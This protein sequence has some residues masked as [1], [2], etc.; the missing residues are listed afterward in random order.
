LTLTIRTRTTWYCWLLTGLYVF[1]VN[2]QGNVVP[3]LQEAFAMSYRAVSLHSSAAAAGIMLVGLFGERVARRLGRQRSLWLAAGGFS[4]GG[5]LLCLAPAPWASITACFVTGL[6]G[7]LAPAVTPVVLADLHGPRRAAAYAGQGIVAYCYGLAAPLLSGL[8]IWAGFG[9]RPAVLA[10]AIVGIAVAFYFR[11]L[12]SAELG[13]TPQSASAAHSSARR[14]SLPAKLPGAY[15]AFWAMVV[16]TVSLEVGIVFWA[17]A[18]LE[19]VVGFTA[20]GAAAAA[21]GFPLG[22]LIGRIL[23]RTLVARVALR[24]LMVTSLALVALG[25]VLYWGIATPVAAIAGVF[26]LGLGIGPT[27]PLGTEFC[28]GAAPAAVPGAQD[29]ASTRLAIAFGLALL[30]APIALGAL[31][32]VLALGPAHLALPVLVL[33]SF[34]TFFAGEALQARDQ[35]S[36]IRDQRAA[37]QAVPSDT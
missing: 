36:G 33:A 32:D 14:A 9:W 1:S 26:I 15:W 11:R 30:A 16:A 19:R 20:A 35:V 28:V 24:R 2:I 5:I 31:A 29:L 4:G 3:F 34:A 37:E 21:A 10:G 18:Y 17:P 7:A 12:G 25:F 8:A 6:F 13:G 27:F 23:L 22:A